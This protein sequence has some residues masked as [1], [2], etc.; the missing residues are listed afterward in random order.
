MKTLKAL[1]IASKPILVVDINGNRMNV[2][3]GTIDDILT[4][5]D[6]N[7]AGKYDRVAVMSYATALVYGTIVY[8]K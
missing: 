7:A 3:N 4:Y 5:K 1:K 8:K 2:R 6:S